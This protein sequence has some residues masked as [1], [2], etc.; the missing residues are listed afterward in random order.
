MAPAVQ[1]ALAELGAT[2]ARRRKAAFVRALQHDNA[3][4]WPAPGV[5]YGCPG[6]GLSYVHHLSAKPHMHCPRCFLNWVPRKEQK[7]AANS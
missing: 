3:A 4:A 7:C 1:H 2:S 6:C 5:H